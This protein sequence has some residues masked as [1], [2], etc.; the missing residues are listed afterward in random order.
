MYSEGNSYPWERGWG[1]LLSG[2]K[3]WT[4]R[5]PRLGFNCAVGAAAT[6]SL[7]AGGSNLL[8]GGVD[9]WLHWVVNMVEA[10]GPE[11]GY[12]L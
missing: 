6:A 4:G 2:G 7:V 1:L 11:R 9:Y 5:F 10:Q 3:G 8:L 12:P